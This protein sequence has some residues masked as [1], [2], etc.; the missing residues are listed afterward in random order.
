MPVANQSI[1]GL[2]YAI[3][4][5]FSERLSAEKVIFH[6]FC[7]KCEY[8]KSTLKLGTFAS[9][10][11]HYYCKPHF[12]QLFTV[13]GNYSEGFGQE[14]PTSKWSQK[15][16]DEPITGEVPERPSI[17]EKSIDQLPE[18]QSGSDSEIVKVVEKRIEEQRARIAAK[19]E[20]TIISSDFRKLLKKAESG[21]PSI[22][23]PTNQVVSF[24][25]QEKVCA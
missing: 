25:K 19:S 2:G 14:K 23:E 15:D 21:G 11:G 10:D 9:M 1:S 13:K 20:E 8:C 24:P 22:T 3:N 5:T 17:I 18:K 6:K 7:F 16:S 4:L 12:K